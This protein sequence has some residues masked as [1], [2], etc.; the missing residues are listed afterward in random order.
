MKLGV[1]YYPEQWSEDIWKQDA[2]EMVAA[3]IEW[4]RIGEFAW[5]RYEPNPGEYQWEWLQRS[6]DILGDAGLKVV[7]GTPTATPPKWLMDQHDD[8]IAVDEAGNPRNYGSRR[9][10]CF[11]SETYRTHCRRIVTEMASKFGKHPAI[12]AWQTDNEYGCHDTIL[13]YSTMA[14]E[15]FREWCRD[16]FNDDISALNTAW[17]NVFWSM[18]FRDFDEIE[19]PNLTVTESNPAHRLDFWR[20]S[21]G[22]VASYNKLQADILRE[23]SPSLDLIHNYMGNF[24]DFDHHD[25]QADLDI[26]SWDSYPLGFLDW[27]TYNEQ[28]KRQWMRTGHPDFAA[29]HHDLYRGVGKGRWWVMEQQP[30][31]VNWAPHNPSPLDGMVRLWSWEAFAHGA[32]VVSYFRWRQA[33][34]AQEQMHSGLKRPDNV[35]DQGMLEAKQTAS[36]VQLLMSQSTTEADSTHMHKEVAFIFDYVSDWSLR[37]QP[38]GNNYNP[39]HWA[40]SI[41]TAC[42]KVGVNVDILPPHA[43]LTGYAT[44]VIANQQLEHDGLLQSLKSSDAQIILGPR[45]FSKTQQYQIPKTLA[46]GSLQSLIPLKVVRVE[47]LADFW[48]DDV[49]KLNAS[50]QQSLT[51]KRWREFVETD[52]APKYKS[53]DGWGL[54]YQHNN[55]HY[56][57]ACLEQDSLN[58]LLQE[59]LLNNDALTVKPCLGGLRQ[60][61]IGKW[62]FFFNYG[63]EEQSLPNHRQLVLGTH[64]LAQGELAICLNE[65]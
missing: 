24:T 5:S 36:E 33:P 30:G 57:N 21:S 20:Y 18:E 41:Y 23:Y 45:S 6:L 51:V 8:I 22:C 27:S 14:L 52:L 48:S 39:L 47:S 19:L 42:R 15:G 58:L 11:S 53:A 9:H 26:A 63:P 54:A 62:Q 16:R 35:D 56:I 55:I 17:G 25:V 31:P 61:K 60:Q 43:D 38:Q 10:Y 44:I 32:E 3:G 65:K 4:V 29:F 59:I 34:F 37:V 12:K 49:N 64:N 2:A 46:P 7:L 13:S 28:E 50:N 40:I 1:C